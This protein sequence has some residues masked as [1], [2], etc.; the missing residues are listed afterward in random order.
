VTETEST[1]TESTLTATGF[2]V[3]LVCKSGYSSTS[4]PTAAACTS[5]GDYTVDA[6]CTGASPAAGL[7]TG[8][9]ISFTPPPPPP[10]FVSS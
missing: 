8:G 5:A 7:A 6:P 1:I 4:T 3:T 9:E 2:A 10:C